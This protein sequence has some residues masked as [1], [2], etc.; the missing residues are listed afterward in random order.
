MRARGKDRRGKW[1]VQRALAG[2]RVQI[3]SLDRAVGKAKKR[4]LHFSL[5]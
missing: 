3:E 2:G 5:N 1:P 4:L